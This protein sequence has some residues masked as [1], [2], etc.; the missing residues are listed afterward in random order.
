[1]K[2]RHE[3][4][5]AT[6][7]DVI[8]A[9]VDSWSMASPQVRVRLGATMAASVIFARGRMPAIPAVLAAVGVG[10]LAERAYLVVHDLHQAAVAVA[11]VLG[12]FTDP[13]DPDS[14]ARELP[15]DFP[16]RAFKTG[17]RSDNG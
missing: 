13:L 16:F 10:V 14:P 9:A 2:M 4:L 12:P 11:G 7:G 8:D 1:M 17:D 5:T 15:D 3:T 6:A